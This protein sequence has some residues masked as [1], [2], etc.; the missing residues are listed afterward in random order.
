MMDEIGEET[1]FFALSYVI[2]RTYF[3]ARG[4]RLGV[5]AADSIAFAILDDWKRNNWRVFEEPLEQQEATYAP[6]SRSSQAD[7]LAFRRQTIH[8]LRPRRWRRK[9]T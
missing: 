8:E 6:T 2:G 5:E 4:S 7:T 3:A 9:S 1:L